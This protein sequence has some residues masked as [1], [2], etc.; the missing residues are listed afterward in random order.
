MSLDG[1]VWRI[2]VALQSGHLK[3]CVNLN[4]LVRQM[5]VL[6]MQ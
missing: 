3:S 5:T 4:R 1:D 2:K 6:V